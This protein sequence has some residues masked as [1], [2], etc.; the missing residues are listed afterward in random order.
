MGTIYCLC[1]RFGTVRFADGCRAS[2]LACHSE[3]SFR[4]RHDASYHTGNYNNAG[5]SPYPC[6]ETGDQRT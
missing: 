5:D 4:E 6:V 2:S 3:R 1:Y